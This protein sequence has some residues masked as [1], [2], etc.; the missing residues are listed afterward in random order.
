MN[1]RLG[2]VL[3]ALLLPACTVTQPAATTAPVVTAAPA[4]HPSAALINAA[5]WQQTAVEYRAGAA[6]TYAA[7]RRMIDA[8]LADP[9]WTAALEQDRI[10]PSMKPAI[11]LDVD[12]TIFNGYE[13]QAR[14]VIENTTYNDD[15]FTEF[16]AESNDPAV[17]GAK[18]FLDYA[19]SRGVRIFYVTN[20]NVA[21][22]QATIDNLRG[23]GL[24]LDADTSNLLAKGDRP[25]W[26]GSDKSPRRRFVAQT[27]RVI[28]LVGD[29]F[30]DFVNANGKTLAER[31]ALFEK[32]EAM[33]GTK[34]FIVANPSYGS[35]ERSVI[36]KNGLTPEEEYE[37]KLK[38]LRTG[39]PGHQ[40]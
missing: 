31:E 9:T 15:T 4:T 22:R 12:E 28:L 38:T 27:H 6:Q 25:E 24:P 21:M 2:Y 17:D 37:I 40:Q 14:Q 5:L 3:A 29:D 32:H 13:Y 39:R 33:F 30:N 36:G 8:A 16:I 10:D 7:A 19:A 26:S 23:A 18:E 11:I 20:R 1:R 35:W 34:W